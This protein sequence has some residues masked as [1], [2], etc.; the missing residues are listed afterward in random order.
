MREISFELNEPFA[1][2]PG[3]EVTKVTLVEPN[4]SHYR[5]TTAIKSE[6]AKAPLLFAQFEK[7]AADAGLTLNQAAETE[8]GDATFSPALRVIPGFDLATIT[9]R[10][11]DIFH[12]GGCVIPDTG[13][14]TKRHLAAMSGADVEAMVD[15]YIDEFLAPEMNQDAGDSDDG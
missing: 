10:V 1:T 12:S 14:L 11:M 8:I 4:G 5:H 7:D 13:T 3:N 2:K 9:Q 6:F 15:R